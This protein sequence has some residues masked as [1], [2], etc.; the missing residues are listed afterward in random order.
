MLFI[1]RVPPHFG[2]IISSSKVPLEMSPYGTKTQERWILVLV[3][4]MLI[5]GPQVWSVKDDQKVFDVPP[6]R[7][8][9]QLLS[10]W[11]WAGLSGLLNW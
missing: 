10:T 8:G 2:L 7:E 6:L 3:F 9:V 1:H 11:T 4:L 5:P